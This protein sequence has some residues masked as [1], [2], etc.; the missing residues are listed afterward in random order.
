MTID[1]RLAAG[2]GGGGLGPSTP[3]TQRSYAA[4]NPAPSPVAD[5]SA[6]PTYPKIIS[7]G[8]GYSVIYLNEQDEMMGGKIVADKEISGGGGGGA[9]TQGQLMANQMDQQKLAQDS[10]LF[11]Q[12]MGYEKAKFNIQ[13][14]AQQAEAALAQA[15]NTRD[16]AAAQH[17]NQVAQDLKQQQFQ[18]DQQ[19]QQFSQY[20]SLADLASNPRNFVQTFFMNRGQTP[21]PDVAKYGNTNMNASQIM[22]FQQFQQRMTGAAGG[23]VAAAPSAPTYSNPVVSQTGAQYPQGTQLSANGSGV[24]GDS[25]SGL[26]GFDRATGKPR[27]S[28]NDPDA[29]GLMAKNPGM[30]VM[31]SPEEAMKYLPQKQPAMYAKGGRLHMMGPHAVINLMTG[32]TVAIAGEQGPE[33]AYFDGAA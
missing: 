5:P 21:P 16:Y 3:F 25:Y 11:F 14:Q 8:G 33:N 31:T 29:A 30:Y 9:A 20:K 26:S 15:N 13:Q 23:G 18:L 4:S 10:E 7:I 6:A 2:L 12:N 22:P 32:K 1:P 19:A 28:P 27:L 24:Y 17:W